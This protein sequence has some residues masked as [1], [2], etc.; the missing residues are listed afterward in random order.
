[1]IRY[2]K[3]ILMEIGDNYIVLENQGIGYQIFI[4]GQTFEY[5][6]DTGAELK[7]YIYF[8]V[9]EDAFVWYGFL[10][11]DDLNIFQ[12]LLGV[13]GVG[14]KGALAILSVLS[15]D[16]LRFAVCSDD[17]KKIA[18]A[19]GVGNKT[20]QRV[21]LELKDKLKLEDAFSKDS[22]DLSPNPKVSQMT[23][24]KNEAL[25]ALTS[26]GYSSSESLKALSSIEC[27]PDDTVENL[28]KAALKQ[29]AFL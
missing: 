24:K 13:N 4:S 6:P 5:L 3:G 11:K 17:V 22:S 26:L 23:E 2:I 12:L 16:D 27:T 14:P 21:V 7:V 9:R 25:M 28:L 18:T 19:P 15:P 29:M 1:M 10:T 20:A 8:Q